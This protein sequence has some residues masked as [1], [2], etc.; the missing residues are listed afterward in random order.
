VLCG[1]PF[2]VS[3][4][5]ARATI[6]KDSISLQNHDV[7]GPLLP[8]SNKLADISVV[9]DVSSKFKV[10]PA[11]CYCSNYSKSTILQATAKA[12][13]SNNVEVNPPGQFS[14][15][16]ILSD[17]TDN[18]TFPSFED[19]DFALNRSTKSFYK[20]NIPLSKEI[21]NVLDSSSLQ[22][23]GNELLLY[24]STF[25]QGKEAISQHNHQV[26]T[27]AV[28]LSQC[29]HSLTNNARPMAQSLRNS[30]QTIGC[31]SNQIVVSSIEQCRVVE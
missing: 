1:D 18:M 5:I 6:M 23:N 8:L 29:V 4:A 28:V 17:R 25:L 26:I 12:G 11:E 27:M 20:C 9:S 16:T 31:S 24:M 22:D 7:D 2:T 10:H 15:E 19:Q 21:T 14:Q 13:F 30:K 3:V